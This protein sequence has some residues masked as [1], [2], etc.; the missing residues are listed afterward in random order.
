MTH[1]GDTPA[2]EVDINSSLVA[3]LV[4]AQFPQ[5]AE[6]PVEPVELGGWDNRTF[7][8]GSEMSVRLPS[9]ERYAQKVEREQSWL[10][11]LAPSLPFPIP[12]PLAMGIPGNGYPWNWSVYRWLEGENATLESVDDLSQFATS[13]G[14]FLVALQKIEPLDGTA[15]GAHNFFRGGPLTTYDAETRDAILALQGKIETNAVTA[16]WETALDASWHGT[17]V[18]LHGDVAP[19]NILVN[20]RQLSAVIDFGGSG[21][22]DPACDLTIA[23]TF[24][25]GASRAAFRSAISLDDATWARARGWAMW[26]ALIILAEHID[27]NPTKAES[28]RRTIQEVL[29]D[30][31]VA[32]GQ[33]LTDRSAAALRSKGG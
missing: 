5:W 24:F 11:V 19:S 17:P 23:W 21:F 3:Q 32:V 14:Q 10:P 29:A 33:G 22:G 6:L 25:F 28:A 4:A 7:R 1:P 27:S 2:L 26:K 8:L 16:V 20:D 12:V 30:H 13:L 31:A 15:P 18:W 9:A